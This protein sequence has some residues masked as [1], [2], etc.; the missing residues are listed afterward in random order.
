MKTKVLL[1]FFAVVTLAASCG[2]QTPK[3]SM[4]AGHAVIGVSDAVYEL[5]WQ[6][7]KDFQTGSRG[8]F[9]DIVRAPNAA[10]VDSLLNERVDEVML[11]RRTLPAET[12]A[13][14]SAKLKLLTYDIALYP[15]YLLVP[16]TNNVAIIDSANFRDVLLGR[17][18]NWK[19]LGGSDQRLTLY[20][21]SPGEGGWAS[22]M[23]YYGHLD[24]VSA[25]VCSTAAQMVALATPDSGAL[26][27]YSKPY[28]DLPFK[29]LTFRRVG[30]DIPANPKTIV[31]E[32]RYPFRLDITYLTTRNKADVAA[33]YLT[34][35]TSNVGQRGIM[36][37]GYRPAS[38]PV[39]VVQM[40]G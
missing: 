13:F 16:K 14:N 2:Q 34:F 36:N 18:T 31:D 28:Q 22:V 20:L 10:L 38:V 15:V 9:V 19:Q 7:S 37:Q 17:V 6:V 35:A 23:S 32:P 5:A 4:T 11:D 12:L 40:K 3:E 21:P 24:S 27:V 39:R 25:V 30:M 33:G 26:L 1:L 29:R 8:A